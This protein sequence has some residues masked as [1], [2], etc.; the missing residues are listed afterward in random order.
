MARAG[1]VA[2]HEDSIVCPLCWQEVRVPDLT[3]E[4]YV[5]Q[6]I[7]GRRKI[8]T[9]QPCNNNRGAD[10]DSHLAGYQRMQDA[11]K[12]L[13]SF[14][15]ELFVNGARLST[16][17]TINEAGK[18]FRVIG[19][20]S[21]PADVQKSKD[22]FEAGQASEFDATIHLRFKKNNFETAALKAGYL[23]A[24]NQF[25][26][27]YLLD[28]NVQAIR[29]RICDLD[30]EY[31]AIKSL[32]VGMNGVEVLGDRQ[33][34]IVLRQFSSAQI[35]LVLIRARIQTTSFLGV[36]LPAPGNHQPEFFETMDAA[37][38]MKDSFQIDLVP[39]SFV[40]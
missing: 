17:L 8:L 3:L 37:A 5:P 34:H 25:G 13:D 26:Y 35:A 15:A 16:E 29:R 18:D 38:A 12:G 10:L 32:V 30:L 11:I 21:N 4:D 19:K 22:V 39:D 6:G 24:F 2:E 36:F 33:H 28:D 7:G 31:P 14:P 40:G 1:L 23:A 20:R 9:C 27:R